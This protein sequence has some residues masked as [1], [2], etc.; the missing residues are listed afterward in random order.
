[1]A[2]EVTTSFRPTDGTGRDTAAIREMS[3]GRH[4][5]Q[6]QQYGHQLLQLLRRIIE[7][8]SNLLGSSAIDL[9]SDALSELN[10]M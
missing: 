5:Y 8:H 4:H 7:A 6:F 2:L 9:A 1:L 10:W 3:P